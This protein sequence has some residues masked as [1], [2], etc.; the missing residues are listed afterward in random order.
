M[1]FNLEE[2]VTGVDLH[3]GAV[4]LVFPRDGMTEVL[5]LLGT[6]S[7]LVDAFVVDRQRVTMAVYFP[8]DAPSPEEL[9]SKGV[10]VEPGYFRL[11]LQGHRLTEGKGLA[12]LW[13]SVLADE[14][15]PLRLSCSDCA[16]ITQYLPDSAKNAVLEL[17]NRTF[18]I[19][20]V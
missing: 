1:K 2:T 20:A 7:A 3:P 13:E 11:T 6:D 15:I 14:K 5:K 19:K 8:E 9:L 18:G 10:I 12:A 17:L 16:G 4:L